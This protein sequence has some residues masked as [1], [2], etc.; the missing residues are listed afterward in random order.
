MSTDSHPQTEGLP[1]RPQGETS[2]RNSKYRTPP[3][4]RVLHLVIPAETF[5]LLHKAAIDSDMKFTHYMHRFLKEAFP[6]GSLSS[7]EATRPA[8][9][10]Y[11]T[12]SS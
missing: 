3:G 12:T 6:Y 4:H 1:L 7:Y 10:L 8:D 9:G 5:A 2:S 11:P